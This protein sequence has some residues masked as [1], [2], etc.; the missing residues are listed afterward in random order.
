MEKLDH[1]IETAIQKTRQKTLKSNQV[2]C[3]NTL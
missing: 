1:R 3:Y 2:G